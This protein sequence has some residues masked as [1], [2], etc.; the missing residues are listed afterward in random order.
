MP[1]KRIRRETRSC[2]SGEIWL[3]ATTQK[4]AKIASLGMALPGVMFNNDDIICI[5]KSDRDSGYSFC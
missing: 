1:P 4:N 5:I 2:D 3:L